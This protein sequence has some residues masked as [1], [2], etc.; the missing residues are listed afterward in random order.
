MIGK[1]RQWVANQGWAG[2]LVLL[3]FVARV[4]GGGGQGKIESLQILDLRRL[5]VMLFSVSSGD[6]TVHVILNIL[7]EILKYSQM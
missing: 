1:D 4:G 7:C 2:V 3:I 5:A 6:E